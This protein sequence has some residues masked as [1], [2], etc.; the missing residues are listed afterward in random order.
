MPRIIPAKRPKLSETQE[1]PA[2]QPWHMHD[3]DDDM[4]DSLDQHPDDDSLGSEL[5]SDGFEDAVM[6]RLDEIIELQKALLTK[7]TDKSQS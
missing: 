1:I 7:F 5:G 4:D 3:S 2:H 6:D